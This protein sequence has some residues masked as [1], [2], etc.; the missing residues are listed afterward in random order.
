MGWGAGGARKGGEERSARPVTL[1]ELDVVLGVLRGGHSVP[2][3]AVLL[4]VEIVL[5]L[6]SLD[7]LLQRFDELNALHLG[8]LEAGHH[9]LESLGAS[10]FFKVVNFL[11]QLCGELL[12]LL[13][14]RVVL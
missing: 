12:V 14:L 11:F 3:I 8:F 4:S 7:F 2:F 9:G 13:L 10:E 5:V 1:N 6:F